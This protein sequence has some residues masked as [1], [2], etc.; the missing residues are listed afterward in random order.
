MVLFPPLHFF[1]RLMCPRAVVL[2]NV[3]PQTG[4]ASTCVAALVASVRLLPSVFHYVLLQTPA[5]V[6]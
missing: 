4:P 5:L 2:V 1:V 3:L 6:T